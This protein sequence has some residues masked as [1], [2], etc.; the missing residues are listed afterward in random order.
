VLKVDDSKSASATEPVD[1]VEGSA[2]APAQT[3]EDAPPIM[4]PM[5]NPSLVQPGTSTAAIASP[6]AA[7]P[8]V[9]DVEKADPAPVS[10]VRV[11]SQAQDAEWLLSQASSHYT[12]QL[13]SLSTE[14]RLVSYIKQQK[15]P[16][17]FAWYTVMRGDKRL[18]VVTYG[19]FASRGEADA[20]LN[21]LPAETGKVQPWVRRMSLVQDAIN[22]AAR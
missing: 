15:N 10:S 19:Q 1:E 5:P 12:V 17:E 3:V 11:P 4:T 2:A 16:G 6:P 22:S 21:A 18:Y 14:D 9:T 13:V 20:A 8:E 7:E